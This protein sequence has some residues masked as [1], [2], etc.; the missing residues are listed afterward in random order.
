MKKPINKKSSVASKNGQTVAGSGKKMAIQPK[1][2]ESA[3]KNLTVGRASAMVNNGIYAPK[4]TTS[5]S[6]S[7]PAPKKT[8][9]KAP[10]KKQTGFKKAMKVGGKGKRC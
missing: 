1:K 7:T 8:K 4:P 2:G 6:K 3:R 9:W 5:A 10:S